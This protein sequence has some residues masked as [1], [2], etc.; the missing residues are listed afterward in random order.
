MKFV[1]IGDSCI[2]SYT[3]CECERLCP[4][5]PVPVLDVIRET[6]TLGMAGNVYNNLLKLTPNVELVTNTNY[7]KIV[8]TRFVEAKTNHMFIRIDTK[9]D[10]AKCN[11]IEYE[12][13]IADADAVVISDYNKGFLDT[14][15]IEV[16]CSLNSNTFLDTKKQL[17]GWCSGCKF[18]KINKG[19]YNKSAK[20]ISEF[21][22]QD[23]IITTIGE[24]GAVYQGVNYPVSKVEIKDLSGAGDTFIAA[25]AFKYTESNSISDAIKFANECATIVVQKKGTSTL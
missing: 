22:L 24:S 8:K 16:I 18:I 14:Y 12:S 21:N 5:A 1:V 19:E 25:L 17:G 13:V 20:S 9:A 4:E 23:K 3:Y 11:L 15:C 2:D 10:I 6:K 7:K